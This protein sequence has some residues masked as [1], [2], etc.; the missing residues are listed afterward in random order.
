MTRS[1]PS[2]SSLAPT[3]KVC[4]LRPPVPNI[5]PTGPVGTTA[6]GLGGTLFRRSSSADFPPVGLPRSSPYRSSGLGRSEEPGPDDR[7]RGGPGPLME[8]P[9]DGWCPLRC[10]PER[11]QE[12]TVGDL[13]AVGV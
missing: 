6:H 4:Y 2:F 7:R 11:G 3:R 1:P 12:A 13:V 10:P 9:T 5:D 8:Q